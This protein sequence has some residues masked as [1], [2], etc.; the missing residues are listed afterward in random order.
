MNTLSFPPPLSV[1]SVTIVPA[2]D[3]IVISRSELNVCLRLVNISTSYRY[4][5]TPLT[6]IVEL[7]TLGG[8]V[9]G[10]T[11]GVLL[12]NVC[13]ADIAQRPGKI[14]LGVTVIV[15]VTGNN[16]L[17]VAINDGILPVPLAPRPIE[18]VLFVQLY[19]TPPT[20]LLKFTAAVGVPV[21]T[22]W[23]AIGSTDAAGYTSTVAV[24]VEPGHPFAVVVMVNVT[25]TD[26]LVVLVSVPFIGVPE[27]LA[28]IPMTV[29]VL[30]LV[31]EKVVPA[32]PL[33]NTMG[34]IADALQ[35]DWLDG[36][37]TAFGVG[38]TS[39]VAVI[40]APG[41]LL[42]VGVIVNVT[43]NGALVVLVNEPLMLP[44]PLAAIPVTVAVLSLVQL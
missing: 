26:A 13:G 12:V 34:V 4:V 19:V 8:A 14:K 40:A 21:H 3:R 25:I 29:A 31:Q 43:V 20:G 36:V 44:A 10:M 38:L 41:Q 15:A 32:T 23:F 18:V 5:G 9:V 35:M 30:S 39:T 37:A 11:T 7:T 2:G 24:V 6:T 27:P 33:I 42:A 28:A 22:V 1:V 16:V 17:L